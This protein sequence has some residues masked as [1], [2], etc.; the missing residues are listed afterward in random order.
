MNEVLRDQLAK[1]AHTLDVLISIANPF[2]FLKV[3]HQLPEEAPIRNVLPLFSLELVLKG[4]SF[5]L[6]FIS[7][8]S[9]G[10]KFPR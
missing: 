3:R 9:F 8:A 7:L 1:A 2:I 10:I 6:G 4:L 5:K